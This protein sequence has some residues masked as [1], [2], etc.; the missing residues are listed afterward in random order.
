MAFSFLSSHMFSND[1]DNFFFDTLLAGLVSNFHPSF[2]IFWVWSVN[3][4][5]VVF[6][7]GMPHSSSNM[8]SQF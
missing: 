8:F 6:D 2:K 5:E 4:S 1:A 3:S 7:Y